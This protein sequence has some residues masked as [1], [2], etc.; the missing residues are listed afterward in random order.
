MQIKTTMYELY[1]VYIVKFILI[2]TIY[3]FNPVNTVTFFFTIKEFHRVYTV[4]FIQSNIIF[5]INV[6]YQVDTV[7]F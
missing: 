2:F 1:H 5:T 6:F 7:T 3:K 4:A